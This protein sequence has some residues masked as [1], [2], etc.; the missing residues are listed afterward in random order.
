MSPSGSS[1]RAVLPDALEVLVP[2]AIRGDQ[3]LLSICRWLLRSHPHCGDTRPEGTLSLFWS[4]E[5]ALDGEA[6]AGHAPQGA[7]A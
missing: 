7:L 4:P 6:R 5:A 1:C 2:C 3:R